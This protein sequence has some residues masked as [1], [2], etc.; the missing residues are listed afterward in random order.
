MKP[1]FLSPRTALL[2]AMAA[3]T[4]WIFFV[5][6]PGFATPMWNVDETIHAAAARTL[7]DGGVMYRDAVDQRT[8]LTYYAMA[9]IFAVAG[10]NNLWAVHAVLAGVITLTGLGLCLLARRAGTPGVGVAA[11]F[12]LAALST[13]LFYASDAN[14]AETEWFAILFTTWGAA[15]FW[16]AMAAPSLRPAFGSGVL[17]GLAFLSKQPALLDLAAPLTVTVWLAATRRWN[18][19]TAGRVVAGLVGGF[20]AMTGAVLLYFAAH[21]ALGDLIFYTWTYNVH[22]YGPEVAALDRVLSVLPLLVM[23]RQE[24][25]LVLLAAA[26]AAAVLAVRLAQFRVPEAERAAQP[27]RLYVLAWSATSLAG[28]ASSGRGYAHYFIQCLPAF[29]LLAAWT[30][31]AAASWVRRRWQAGP[32]LWPRLGLAT[33]SLPLLAMA[34][35]LV[36]GP[37]AGRRRPVPP[38]D[39]AL[40]SAAFIK[41]H[42]TPDERIFVWGYNPDIYLYADR[43]PASRFLYCSFQ[44][45]LI[46]WTNLAPD[47]DTTYAIVPGAMQTL[48]DELDAR[49]PTFIVDCSFGPHRHFSK[50]PIAK[51]PA[52]QAFVS[53]HYVVSD[54][55]QFDPQ[56]FRLYQI[57]DAAR[58]RPVVLAGGPPASRLAAPQVFGP[59]VVGADPESFFV[60]GEDAAGRLQRLE[61]LADNEAVDA[62]SFPPTDRITLRF[63]VPFDR[64][65]VG[66]HHLTVHATAADGAVAESAAAAIQCDRSS[67]PP[68]KLPAFGMPCVTTVVAPLAIRAPFGPTAGWE[69]GHLVFFAHAPSALS[70]PLA[71]HAVRVRGRFGFRPGAFAADNP[72]PTDGADFSVIW[73]TPGEE[74]RVLFQR[75]LQ[76]TTHPED[77]PL[78][79]FAA[80][81]P[82][83]AAGGRIEFVISPG[84]VGNNACDWT[85]W[86]DLAMETPP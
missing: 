35:S 6:W 7:L 86:A 67:V 17:F 44:T 24:Y 78:Q 23:F 41:G 82:E 64:L 2:L 32:S 11:A 62:V 51:F 19:N 52:L 43:K 71:P 15:C 14:A 56:G 69:D 39:P 85:Y 49:R 26:A 4:A 60:V 5:R 16:R 72:S 48:L 58:R 68:E 46:P 45:G 21:G 38:L 63:T 54:P 75:L 28:A 8:P 37:L 59:P 83:G 66:L 53:A 20:V 84:P 36:T 81:L 47:K 74:R 27:W 22:Y 61:L 33:L 18:L 80:A 30:L 10:T 42:T 77:R 79:S 29:S 34:V 55:A 50:Y 73:V 1:S 25:P 31:V 57:K 40:R 12:V 70:Y 9:A 13:N 76:P 65:G 3:L